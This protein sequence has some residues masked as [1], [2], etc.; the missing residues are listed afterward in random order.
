MKVARLAKQKG[1]L[2]GGI[3]AKLNKIQVKSTILL[4]KLWGSLEM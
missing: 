2:A 4:G 3:Y 1:L